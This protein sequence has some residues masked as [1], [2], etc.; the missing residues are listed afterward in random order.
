MVNGRLRAVKRV[1]RRIYPAK[2]PH[3]DWQQLLGKDFV[4]WEKLTADGPSAPL[5]L[6]ATSI[7]TPANATLDSLLAVAL[8]LRGA[9]VHVLLCDEA[10]PAC[11]RCGIG[12]FT[13]T[14]AFLLYG[15]KRDLCSSCFSQG[16]EMFSSLGIIVH[17]YSDFLTE[18]DICG[19]KEVS[20]SVPLDEIGNYSVSGV[21]VGEHALAGA[22]RFYA[23]GTLDGEEKGETVLR[24]YFRG[25]LLTM[26]AV[27][28]LL[29]RFN[30]TCASFHNGI[31]VPQGVVGAVARR[32]GVRVVN[33]FVAYRKRTFIFSHGDTYHHTLMTEPISNWE[34]MPWSPQTEVELLDYLKSR[35]GGSRD[36]ISFNRAPKE[37]LDMIEKELGVN[38]SSFCI[39]LLTNVMWDAQL[40]YPANA[41]SN[42]LE[43][44]F[45]TIR[46]FASHSDL[47]LIIRIHPAEIRGLLPSRQFVLDEIRCEFPE[48]P[49]NV[50]VIPPDSP[51]STYAVM[52]QCD[53]VLIYGTKTGVE[54]TSM[55]I[56]VIVAGEAWI[57]NK[58]LTLD[59][60]T[61]ED[62]L[63]ILDKLPLRYRLE[64]AKLER[65]RKYAYHFFFRRMIP[66]RS[67]V[68]NDGFPVYKIQIPGLE[69]LLP[70]KDIGLDVICDGILHGKEF[71]YPAE[72]IAD[73]LHQN[74]SYAGFHLD[75][76]L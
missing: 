48:L 46:Y 4:L 1:I 56:P 76:N 11:E 43:W 14:K 33:W 44:L 74:A 75:S 69:E 15:P 21:E 3:P 64:G 54:L 49:N 27:G 60:A 58:G 45:E 32:A 72:C 2:L 55:G 12:E 41:F 36:W 30:Y 61:P 42:M 57:R 8:R 24:Q 63:K 34:D 51:V 31:Y 68:P 9:A 17:R 26:S 28:K 65:A 38:F 23:R 25:A 73:S 16:Y 10:L 5:I 40:H 62:Y 47:Q 29:E 59:A 18:N 20:S 22:L 71:I 6:I 39:G 7:G 67:V 70:G 35:W 52:M 13:D 66:L 19:A 50:F 53:S 37:D